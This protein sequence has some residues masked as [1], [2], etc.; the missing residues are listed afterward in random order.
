[1]PL[2]AWIYMAGRLGSASVVALLGAIVVVAVGAYVYD[3]EVIWSAV[4]AMLVT[5]AAAMFCFCALGLA[6]TVLVPSAR[7]RTR[8]ARRRRLRDRMGTRLDHRARR[9]GRTQAAGAGRYPIV[10]C[11]E[12]PKRSVTHPKRS[13]NG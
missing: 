5:L 6:V 3:F 10:S 13:L 8:W 7:R 9:A 12:T 4:P 1:M 11:Q 2:P